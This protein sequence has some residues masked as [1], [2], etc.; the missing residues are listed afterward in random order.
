MSAY[1]QV[2]SV[3][4]EAGSVMSNSKNIT[5]IIIIIN[6]QSMDKQCV[7]CGLKTLVNL[8]II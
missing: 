5:I 4:L 7:I 6:N 1:W 2:I 3:L 8:L